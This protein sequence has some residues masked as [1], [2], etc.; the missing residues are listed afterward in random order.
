[1]FFSF[2]S[3]SSPTYYSRR[4]S[5]GFSGLPLCYSLWTY[6]LFALPRWPFADPL[7]CSNLIF[8]MHTFVWVLS[9]VCVCAPFNF[10]HFAMHTRTSACFPA[11]Y[12]VYRRMSL[13]PL[14]DRS[15]VLSATYKTH[16]D[17]HPAQYNLAVDWNRNQEDFTCFQAKRNMLTVNATIKSVQTNNHVEP[18]YMVMPSFKILQLYS[19]L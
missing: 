14:L 1:M 15:A 19:D 9:C 5:V 12:L 3:A 17:E 2:L 7:V 8:N 13:S 11:V 6:A 18:D 4:C 16:R 10:I